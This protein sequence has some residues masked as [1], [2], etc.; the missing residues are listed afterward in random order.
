MAF[1][2]NLWALGV[3]GAII[4][5]SLVALYRYSD[6]TEM[7]AKT[8]RDMEDLSDRMRAG[9]TADLEDELGLV[10]GQSE[11]EPRTVTMEGYSEKPTNP[12]GSDEYRQALRRFVDGSSK[13]LVDYYGACRA[14]RTWSRWARL[15]SWVVLLLV[16]WQAICI[17][18]LGGAGKLIALSIPE[19]ATRLSFLPSAVFVM[20]FFLC[21]VV[22]LHQHDIIH[23]SK[24]QYPAF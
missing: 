2:L 5:P 9:I 23:E 17:A 21:Q 13:A 8:M 15:L 7:F 16:L 11:G 24:N 18:T 10:F 6:R 20:L 3:H 19:T 1:D 12:V 14:R 4:V 22:L